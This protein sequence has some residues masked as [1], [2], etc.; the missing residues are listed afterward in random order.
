MKLVESF[1]HRVREI[2]HVWISM[3]D[4]VRLSARIWRPEDADADPVPA[5]LE[6]IPYRKRDLMRARDEPMHRYFAG[7]GYAA[8]RLD[9]RGSGE[10]EGVLTDEYT[11]RELDDGVEAIAWIASQKWC[12]GAVGMMGKSWGGFNAL[13][14]AALRPPALR[15]VISVC[16]TDDRYADDVHYMGGQLITDNFGWGSAFFSIAAQPPDPALVGDA[17]RKM[18]LERLEAVHPHTAT[19]LA[20]QRRDSYW[21]HGSVCDDFAA[22]RCAVYAIGGWADG[23][24]N[25]IPRLLGGLTSPRKGL[26]GPW[27]HLYPHDGVPGPAIGYLQECLRW[28]DHWL[29]GR[30]TGVM[31][32]PMYRAW[33]Q[34]GV[35]PAPFYE[36]RPGRWV[37]EEAWPSPRIRMVRMPFDR[38]RLAA[39]GTN[40]EETKLEISSPLTVG[41]A[42]GSWIS[43]GGRGDMPKDQRV[44]DGGSLVFDS[45]P[46]ADVTEILGAP[47]VEL[48]IASDKPVAM[49]AVRLNDIAPDGAATRVT[50]GLLNLTHRDGHEDPAP[51]D[52]GRRYRVRVV[53]NDVAHG[54]AA[55]HRLRVAISTSYWPI[56]WPAPELACLTLFTGASALE[57]P[58]RPL[59]QEDTSLRPF[60]VPESARGPVETELRTA[61]FRRS[62]EHDVATGEIVHASGL[63]SDDLAQGRRVRLDDIDLEYGQAMW[64]R[65]RITDGDPLSAQ[66]EYRNR[67][68]FK[69]DGWN[70]AI[71]TRT[72][73]SATKDEFRLEADM[74]AYEGEAKVFERKWD[75]KIPRD[76]M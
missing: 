26:V 13:Q 33:M 65:L 62:I 38:D 24:S 47:V 28:W 34:A 35:P 1:P 8:I 16:S 66:L 52:P 68:D 5:I 4:G 55:R 51:L 67:T 64:R 7:H 72:R 54:F 42:S 74:T 60:G 63:A 49:L 37:A 71:E 17:W 56:A 14:I 39:E 6:Y 48:D 76:L 58:V 59:R 57:L 2:E 3:S 75:Y 30:Y 40:V 23:Y 21:K 10:S 41:L 50:Y 53:L 31:A 20:H 15:A 73:L 46:L 45:E 25:A 9:V 12:S 19:W 22:I 70:P 29:K 69:R 32:E 43:F 44:D 27:G 61:K 18:W 11:Q 36:E